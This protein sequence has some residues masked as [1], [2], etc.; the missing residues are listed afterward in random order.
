[1]KWVNTKSLDRA[2]L[3]EG[4]KKSSFSF[5]LHKTDFCFF[6]FQ[7]NLENVFDVCQPCT[8]SH[9]FFFLVQL[10]CWCYHRFY[11]LLGAN[12]SCKFKEKIITSLKLQLEHL[13]KTFWLRLQRNI[14]REANLLNKSN[15]SSFLV[16][17]EIQNDRSIG[18]KVRL[19]CPIFLLSQL[20]NR[21]NT[22]EFWLKAMFR[23]FGEFSMNRTVENRICRV[24][25]D[26]DRSFIQQH[27][28]TQANQRK[29]KDYE[30]TLQDFYRM[31]L[32]ELES[33]DETHREHLLQMYRSYLENTAG[34]K[35]AIRQL[36]SEIQET[37]TN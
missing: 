28:A 2:A 35:K 9:E 31:H 8:Q 3:N 30:R 1:M 37:E 29:A 24:E 16:Q 26:W 17:H 5:T 20:E 32:D 33:H 34:S 19:I 21:S 36:C 14:L 22:I 6:L 13:T 10:E 12:N 7:T 23:K 18:I 27:Q 25:F 15:N 11:Y 4:R